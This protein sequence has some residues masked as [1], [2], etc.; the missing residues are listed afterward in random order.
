MA[1]ILSR[2]RIHLFSKRSHTSSKYFERRFA[3]CSLPFTSPTMTEKQRQERNKQRLT[4]LYRSFAKR[5][6]AVIADLETRGFRP[7]IQD[8]WRS[9]A[10]QLKAFNSGHSKLKYGFHDVTAKDGTKEGLAVDLL[11]DDHASHETRQYLLNHADAAQK[12]GHSTGIRGDFRSSS[13]RPSMRQL[14]HHLESSNYSSSATVRLACVCSESVRH[15]WK[16]SNAGV[17]QGNERRLK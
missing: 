1:R 2:T 5:I 11:D 12:Q 16:Q 15:P 13:G 4:E 7:R 3:E 17:A 9:P 10:D 14:L 6:A 8:A